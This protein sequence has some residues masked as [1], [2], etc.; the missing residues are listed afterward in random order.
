ME[1]QMVGYI[2][3]TNSVRWQLKYDFLSLVLECTMKIPNQ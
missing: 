1:N 3:G 2:L